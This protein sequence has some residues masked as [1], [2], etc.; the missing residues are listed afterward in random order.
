MTA[1]ETYAAKTGRKAEEMLDLMAKETWFTA[2]EAKAIGMVDCVRDDEAN[3]PATAVGAV[4]K[5]Q[6]APEQLRKIAASM[7]AAREAKEQEIIN[8]QQL[9]ELQDT[10]RIRN[11]IEN[12]QAMLA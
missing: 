8:G 6:R 11:E 7:A 12:E 4:L 5:Y 3:L 10:Q 1:A 2:D 9:A